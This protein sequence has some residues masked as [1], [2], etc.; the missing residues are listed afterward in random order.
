MSQVLAQATDLT[1]KHGDHVCAFY[2]KSGPSPQEIGASYL[3]EGLQ[4]GDKCLCLLDK[5]DVV[6]RRIPKRLLSNE[7]AKGMFRNPEDTYLPEGRFSKEAHIDRLDIL[8][9]SAIKDGYQR[10][11]LIADATFIIRR[12]VD[13]KEWFVYEAE[14]NNFAPRYP[15]L[16]L[17]LYDLDQFDGDMVIYI[18]KTHPRILVNGL[19]INNPYYLSPHDFVRTL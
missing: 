10:F 19:V 14:V 9:S 15:Q 13:T 12:A 5:P 3:T 18:L 16:L 11:R 8:V 2:S 7:L 6:R 4:A 1:F 17:C